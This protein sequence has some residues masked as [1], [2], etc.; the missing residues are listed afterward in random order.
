MIMN[1]IN[2]QQEMRM[3]MDGI[4]KYFKYIRI[5]ID[6]I[7]AEPYHHR[8]LYSLDIETEYKITLRCRVPVEK[9]DHLRPVAYNIEFS[10]IASLNDDFIMG[11]FFDPSA[12]SSPMMIHRKQVADIT[13]AFIYAEEKDG[14][15]F[16]TAVKE[17]TKDLFYEAY[18]KDFDEQVESELD[19]SDDSV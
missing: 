3:V 11:G 5:P 12:D 18:E 14:V 17:A 6:E 7:K 10:E 13:M 2:K 4:L 9:V 8:S 16:L 15:N 19:R 1:E